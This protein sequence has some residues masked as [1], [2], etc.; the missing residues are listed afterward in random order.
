MVVTLPCCGPH[1]RQ[2]AQGGVGTVPVDR[3]TPD[4]LDVALRL[5]LHGT[6]HVRTP[7]H[8]ESV[9][10]PSRLLPL[11]DLPQK[12]RDAQSFARGLARQE[13]APALRQMSALAVMLGALVCQETRAQKY[14]VL[15]VLFPQR[16]HAFV[17]V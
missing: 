15:A 13:L 17:Q 11:V 10:R 2:S 9:T 7:S 5:S 16:I 14:G 4:R 3:W 6:H 8:A 1:R 12:H